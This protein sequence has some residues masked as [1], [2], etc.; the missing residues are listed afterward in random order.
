MPSNVGTATLDLVTGGRSLFSGFDADLAAVS[1]PEAKRGGL[2]GA[3]LFGKATL[4]ALAPLAL[5]AGAAMLGQA[6]YG[7]IRDGVVAASELEQ[8]VGAVRTVFGA[9][10]D[11][12]LASA[13][14]AAQSVGLTKNAYASLA[15]QLGTS[16]K[17]AGVA[18]DQLA[19]K[20]DGVIRIGADLAAQFGGDTASAVDAIS[21]AFRGE[22]DPIERYGVSLTA[23]AVSAEAVRLR[24]IGSGDE[25]TAGARQAATLSLVQAQSADAMGAFG[26]ESDTLSNKQQRL[27][28]MLGDFSASVGGALL[29]AVSGFAGFMIVALGPA[30]A[31]AE[32]VVTGV[33]VG[34]SG[35]YAALTGGGG[36]GGDLGAGGTPGLLT[37]LAGGAPGGAGDALPSLVASFFDVVLPV[38]SPLAAA[39]GPALGDTA[40]AFATGAAGLGPAFAGL[41]P[42]LL[43]VLPQ[44]SP[45]GVLLRSL[46]PVLPALAGIAGQLAGV[47]ADGLGVVLPQSYAVFQA[48]SGLLSSYLAVVLP[49]LVNG[50]GDFA[51]AWG[52][53]LFPAV[54]AL[55][56]GL[57]PLVAA[58]LTGLVP[59]VLELTTALQSIALDALLAAV[60]GIVPPFAELVTTTVGVAVALLAAVIAALAPPL[61]QLVTGVLPPVLALLPTLLPAIMALVEG[62]SGTLMPV[63]AALLPVI[64][65]VFGAIQ[66]VV[67]AALQIVQGVIAVATGLISGNWGQVWSGLGQIVA[68]VWSAVVALIRGALDVVRALIG[69]LLDRLRALFA[70]AWS[71]LTAVVGA[72]IG[73]LVD[74]IATRTAAVL[75]FVGGLPS[76][77]TSAVRGLSG[78][79]VSVGRNTVEGFVEGLQAMAGRIAD[80]V[81]GPIKDSVEGVK[82]FL[83][84]HSPSTLM[85]DEAEDAGLAL[86]DSMTA[87]TPRPAPAALVP[88]WQ[89]LAPARP[90][91]QH[92]YP[93]PGMSETK[94]ADALRDALE[95][96]ARLRGG[97]VRRP[98]LAPVH[99]IHDA[100]SLRVA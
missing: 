15:V 77:I 78:L 95:A 91:E 85:R 55:W 81:L 33:I 43:T 61:V 92:L 73:G 32:R 70:S 87:S 88:G 51:A 58:L 68:G 49:I 13:D 29:P 5:F 20:T 64:A 98:V 69:A 17:N 27:G 48:L 28:A 94:L 41:L 39:L 62:L 96:N 99:P 59:V 65:T 2:V 7:K 50:L 74:G 21:S 3:D 79:L 36:F 24:L 30:L 76:T 100:P 44:V 80:S 42:T 6:A 31:G 23:A 45:L 54:V 10:A 46:L 86:V 37:E 19:P 83:G 75:D 18:A 14:A 1:K 71:G 34:V 93:S 22:L 52:G 53:Q 66:A 84:I 4:R 35:I 9:S 89:P 26:R 90:V 12:T 40:R 56:S 57:L 60:T 97:V 8:S 63:V 47:V 67:Q 25:L 38:L 16:M 11:Q 72:S 82:D